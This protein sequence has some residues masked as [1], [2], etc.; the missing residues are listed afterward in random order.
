[1][2]FYGNIRTKVYNYGWLL[3]HPKSWTYGKYIR[4]VQGGII[5]KPFPMNGKGLSS[6]FAPRV[7]TMA[8]W[9]KEKIMTIQLTMK[10]ITQTRGVQLAQY[11]IRDDIHMLQALIE[12]LVDIEV[13]RFEEK[14]LQVTSQRQLDDM[15][16]AGKVSFGFKYGEDT[17]DRPFAK[18][19]AVLAFQDGLYAVFLNDT[20]IEELKEP[21]HLK[22]ND[23]L[24]LIRFTMLAGRYF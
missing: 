17:I 7:H 23:I 18:K 14:E 9:E 1:M 11:H 20:Q 22:E 5:T 24:T 2:D 3:K 16:T 12:N 10:S 21:L 8:P 15:V 19:V 6:N 13:T 4:C